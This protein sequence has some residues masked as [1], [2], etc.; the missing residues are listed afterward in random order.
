MGL[1]WRRAAQEE[2]A[3]PQEGQGLEQ[4]PVS[5]VTRSPTA[6]WRALGPPPD[7]TCP[8]QALRFWEPRQGCRRGAG[9]AAGWAAG[10]LF[11]KRL[12]YT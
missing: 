9:G 3:G 11:L 4:R 10:P 1:A 6:L 8:T 7:W 5:I 12:G 2:L